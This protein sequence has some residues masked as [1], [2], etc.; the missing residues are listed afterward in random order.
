MAVYKCKMCSANLEINNAESVITCDYCGTQ[1]TLPKLDSDRRINLYDRANHFRR[2]NEFDKA[3]NIYEKILNEDSTDAEAYWSIVLCRFGIEYVEEKT[4]HKRIPTVHRVQYTSIFDDDNYKSALQYADGYQRS[5]YESEAKTIN[6]IQKNIL[7]ISQKEEPF[8]VFICY[9]ETDNSGKRTHDSVLANELYHELTQRGLKVFFARITLENKLGTAYEP[10]IFAALNSAKIM[11]VIGT[12]QEYFNAVWVKNEWSR[13]LSLIKQGQKKMLIPAYRD[14]DPYDLP[15]EFSHLQALDMSKLGFMPD[16]IHGIE[17]IIQYNTPK[18]AAPSEVVSAGPSASPLLKR[19]FIFLEDSDWVSADEYCEKA[20]DIDPENAMA[21]LGKLMAKLRVRTQDALK[22]QDKPFNNDNN[23]QKAIRFGDS[24]LKA[25]LNG[26]INFINNRNETSR[27]ESTYN[28]AKNLISVGTEKAF[29]EAKATFETI[30]DFKDSKNLS[31]KCQEMAEVARKDAILDQ[32]KAKMQR[33]NIAD[34][35]YAINL[36]ESI[37]GWKDANE[38]IPICKNKIEE[39]KADAEIARK[40]GI[41]AKGKSLMRFK[42]ISDYKSAIALFE[43]IPDWRDANAQINICRNE[44]EKIRAAEE[45]KRIAEIQQAELLK[46]T[47]AKRAR[48]GKIIATFISLILVAAISYVIALFTVIMPEE[49]YSKA[50]S[51][52]ESGDYKAAISAFQELNGYKD[53]NEKINGCYISIYGKETWDLISNIK[54]GDSYVLGS[55]EQDNDSSNGK[56][57]IEWI[58]LAKEDSK[59]LLISEYALDCLPF[60]TTNESVTWENCTLRKWLNQNFLN[61]A[62]TSNEK[63]LISTTTVTADKNP[64]YDKDQ[65]KDTEDKIFLLSISEA[66]KYFTNESRQCH[67]TDYAVANGAYKGDQHVNGSCNWLLR[68]AGAY[69]GSVADVNVSGRIHEGGFDVDTDDYGVRPAMWIDL[70]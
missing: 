33:G 45:A 70:N 37:S 48:R 56:E 44:I 42:S 20:L 52:M 22:D 29:R 54:V 50:V 32:G 9:K 30:I 3:A 40:D 47:E 25:K 4:T 41:L 23:F 12:K 43:S 5:I 10:Y 64:K 49:K 7:A 66:E 35:K 38:Q 24:E 39:L 27:L 19:A 15:E 34:Y 51:L 68:T 14:M 2:N 58:V 28:Y 1:Q 63:S 67:P 69:E 60:N 16:L 46:K 53:S 17:K 31:E 18:K 6:E 57:E 26:Y 59:I 11:V 8:D 65:G 55:Y 21:Y 61:E 36:F 13:Y 62:F